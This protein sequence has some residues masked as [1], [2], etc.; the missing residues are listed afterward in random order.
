MKN[1]LL[2]QY[3]VHKLTELRQSPYAW[4]LE[5]KIEKAPHQIEAFVATIQALQTGG[6]ILADEVGLGKTIE[7]G[8]ILKY[9]IKNGAKRILIAMPPP[10]R[11]QWQDELLEKFNIKAV[12]PESKYSVQYR[13]KDHWTYLTGSPKPLVVIT[14]YAFASWFIKM[15]PRVTWDCFVFDEAHRLRNFSNGAKMPKLLFDA[16]RYV[17]KVMLTATPL[18]NNLRELYALSQYIDEHIFVSEKVFNELYVKPEDYKGLREA[19][20][21]ILHRTLRKDVADYMSF[22]KRESMTVDFKLSRDEA[23]LYQLANDYLRRPVLYAVSDKNNALIKM[24]VRKLL[25]SSSY[26]VIETFEVLR[27]RLKILK[28]NTRAEKADIS[29]QAFFAM[30]DDDD[31]DSLC[32]DIEEDIEKIE[33][34]RYRVEIDNELA[35]VENIIRMASK[36]TENSK[37]K[38]VIEALEVAFDIQKESGF[39]E[40][41]LIFTESKRTQ[42]Y[43]VQALTNAGFN[44]IIVFNGEMNDPETKIIYNAWRARN[45]RR[46]TNTPSIDLKQAIIEQFQFEA[47]ILIA[48]DA[49]SEGLN[50]QFC[51]T[52]INYDLPW[53]PMKIEQRIGRCHRYGQERDVWVYNLLNR[54]NQADARVYEILE[55]KFNLF[56]G[57]FGASDEALGLLESGTNFERKVLDIYEHCKTQTDFKREFD[58]LEREITAKRGKKANELKQIL[59]SMSSDDKK[60]HLSQT[61]KQ[62]TYYIE[63]IKQWTAISENV[64]SLFNT[65]QQLQG[66]DIEISRSVKHGYV[67]VGALIKQL[68]SEF[69]C[70][71][72]LVF[73]TEGKLL[74]IDTREIVQVFKD[75]DENYFTTIVPEKYEMDLINFCYEQIAPHMAV[76]YF[77]QKKPVIEQN[78]KRIKNW[79]DNQRGQYKA[80]S[81]DLRNQINNLTAQK[82]A[83][84]LFQEKIDI[85]KKI[86]KLQKQ[87][88]QRDENFH[89]GMTAIERQA[90]E[91]RVSFRKQFEFET[92]AL[93]NL[94]V[95]F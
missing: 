27:E 45:P 60:K 76:R 51:D 78:D 58:R 93:I 21:P 57:V 84:K 65:V 63:N 64:K 14:S 69:I 7:A 80:E 9:L 52:V 46:V 15:F 31:D 73:D 28:Q 20:S 12:I 89:S 90:D 25:A 87:L 79:I 16:T 85:Q 22:C 19:I 13:D 74:D 55:N 71:I 41:A 40:K 42:K 68:K 5:S 72:L 83:S 95:K 34:D 36:I 11:K 91:E 4:L 62:I 1:A 33:R 56:K 30:I 6:I 61:A 59:M 10:L 47:K 32:D 92:F 48:T 23:I 24:V 29:L 39:P 88:N 70:P 50:L 8:L 86:D 2:E 75:I 43:L 37:I 82:N 38:A 94:V 81:D 18:Q 54:E 49:A 77:E 67:F 26:A 66:V 53:N 35:V 17:P 3:G 44:G